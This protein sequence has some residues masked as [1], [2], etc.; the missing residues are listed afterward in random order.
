MTNEQ[1]QSSYYTSE[2][3]M[4]EVNYYRAQRITKAMLDG[5]LISSGE[6]NKLSDINRKTFYPLFAEIM[7]KI[8]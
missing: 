2:R 3:I 4:G 8:T 6:F 1:K 7:P 5:G